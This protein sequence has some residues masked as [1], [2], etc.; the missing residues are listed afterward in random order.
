MVLMDVCRMD[1]MFTT[2]SANILLLVKLSVQQFRGQGIAERKNL[3]PA[4]LAKKRNF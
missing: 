3:A 2:K 4:F 1:L